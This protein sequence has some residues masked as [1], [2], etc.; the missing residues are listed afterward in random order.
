M[1]AK[2]EN[3]SSGNFIIGHNYGS[4]VK[5]FFIK[6]TKFSLLRQQ[7]SFPIHLLLPRKGGFVGGWCP[8]V[9]DTINSRCHHHMR[10]WCPSELNT[11]SPKQKDIS[12]LE[13]SSLAQGVRLCEG[14]LQSLAAKDIYRQTDAN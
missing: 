12:A 7:R 5:H 8:S 4:V 9:L 1:Q 3:D 14:C 6:L 2:Q 13:E 11:Q 10:S